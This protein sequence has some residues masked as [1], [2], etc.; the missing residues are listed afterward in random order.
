MK[1]KIW[2]ESGR[3]TPLSIAHVGYVGSSYDQDMQREA[4]DFLVKRGFEHSDM[5]G[6][7]QEDDFIDLHKGRDFLQEDKGYDLVI[8]YHLF[9]PSDAQLDTQKQIT[10][11]NVGD[12]GFFAVSQ[13]HCRDAWKRRLETC[14]AEAIICFGQTWERGSPSEIRGEYL[15]DLRN[16]TREEYGRFTAYLS[17]TFPP[18]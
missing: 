16:Y 7:G 1:F 18:K 2:L 9:C 6:A 5:I 4:F 11:K 17:D 13:R 12:A 10:A 8:L 3:T 15:G 14:Y